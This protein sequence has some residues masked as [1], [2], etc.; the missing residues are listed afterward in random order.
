MAKDSTKINTIKE[1][2]S[3]EVIAPKF[4]TRTEYFNQ[5]VKRINIGSVGKAVFLD[6]LGKA[7]DKI[8]NKDSVKAIKLYNFNLASLFFLKDV[9]LNKNK[10]E[11]V[12]DYEESVPNI[13][14]LIED[15]ETGEPT[16]EIQDEKTTVKQE[17]DEFLS[18][19]KEK[20]IKP[21]LKEV[22]TILQRLSGNYKT[23]IERLHK[24]P[25]NY[26][27]TMGELVGKST[28]ERSLFSLP[29]LISE[30]KNTLKKNISKN[31]G[32][33]GQYLLELWQ[34]NN[35]QDLVITNLSVL[36]EKLNNTNYETKMY[37]LYLGGYTY[38][39]IDTN[40]EGELDLVTE[41]LFRIK[42]TYGKDVRDAYDRGDFEFEK[43]G[44][45]KTTMLLKQRI[46]HITVTPNER[47]INAIKG[48]GLGNVLVVSD[49]FIKLSLSLTDIAYKIFSYSASNKPNQKIG[50]AGLI[51]H[52]G[53][54]IKVKTQGMPR[55]RET[56]LKGFEELKEKEH[57][58]E[59]LFDYNT[60]MYSFSYTNKF[61]RH[62]EGERDKKE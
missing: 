22:I 5:L 50:E 42:F 14:Q 49:N 28:G 32:I 40:V 36:S 6:V 55:I 20:D 15:P 33:L 25:R 57:I 58:K 17:I 48:K 34:E 12:F 53:L 16:G 13:G 60:K 7:E 2:T 61:I 26:L 56:I 10:L 52:L 23:D 3:K 41:Q 27:K 43:V 1:G 46:K 35:N 30:E 54:E 47:F 37:L 21:I 11:F 4:D 31:T 59:Y 24:Q 19:T 51:K 8:K 18:L 38:P 62:K 29:E 9:K 39:I 44:T 45:E